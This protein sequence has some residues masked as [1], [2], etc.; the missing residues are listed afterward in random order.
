MGIPG[1]AELEQALAE[2]ARMREHGEDPHH[3]AKALLSHNYRLQLLQAVLDATRHYLHSGLAPTEH[4]ALIRAIAAAEKAA[5][6]TG[7]DHDEFGL[8]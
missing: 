1:K 8:E 2:A 5:I 3:V 7:K 4:T 6:Q